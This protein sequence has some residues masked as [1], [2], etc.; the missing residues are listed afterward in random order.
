M[1]LSTCCLAIKLWAYNGKM[2]L[3]MQAVT[4]A[5]EGAHPDLLSLIFTVCL[6]LNHNFPPRALFLSPPIHVFISGT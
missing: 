2:I 4:I 1:R 6:N 5:I 3:H